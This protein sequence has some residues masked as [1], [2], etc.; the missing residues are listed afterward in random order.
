[1][2]LGTW[3]GDGGPGVCMAVVVTLLPLVNHHPA[4]VLLC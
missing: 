3:V 4:R 2:G 1:M